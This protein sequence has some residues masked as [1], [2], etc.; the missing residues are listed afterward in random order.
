[1]T[2]YYSSV[3]SQGTPFVEKLLKYLDFKGG[4]YIEAGANDGIAQSNTRFLEEH[5]AWTGLLIEPSRIAF[6]QLKHNRP[7]SIRR[8]VC[9]VSQDY[10][11]EFVE[12]DFDGHLMSSVGGRRRGADTALS[13]VPCSTLE[14]ILDELRVEK[15]DFFSLDTEGYEFEVLR[16]MNLSRYHPRFILIEIYKKD[17]RKIHR[18]LLD[19]GYHLLECVSNFSKRMNPGWDGT[20]NDYLYEYRPEDRVSGLRQW[21]ASRF[22]YHPKR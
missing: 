19:H 1:M 8:N 5:L 20:H 22:S 12:G 9:L 11:L 18:Y 2:E 15:V 6:E 13:K 14:K 4:F 7:K 16:G 3:D 10:P 21:F 17:L